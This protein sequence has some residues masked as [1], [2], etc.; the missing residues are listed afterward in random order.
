MSANS[1]SDFFSGDDARIHR[2]M[3]LAEFR[4]VLRV[5]VVARLTRLAAGVC[6][7]ET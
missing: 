6:C 1:V 4:V 5:V 7:R 3:L 2:V